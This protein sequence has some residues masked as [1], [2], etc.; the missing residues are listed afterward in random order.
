ME[1]V[2][3][4]GMRPEDPLMFW[5]CGQTPKWEVLV[6]S[7]RSSTDRL[8]QSSAPHTHGVLSELAV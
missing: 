8:T 4:E 1:K 7:V 2:V 5:P 6:E 3:R